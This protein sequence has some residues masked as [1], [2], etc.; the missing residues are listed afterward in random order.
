MRTKS[1]TIYIR[2][3][4]TARTPTPSIR[5]EKFEKPE[6]TKVSSNYSRERGKERNRETD[7]R[8]MIMRKIRPRI[9]S[10]KRSCLLLSRRRAIL[11][12]SN[13]DS[14]R[15]YSRFAGFTAITQITLVEVSSNDTRYIRKERELGQ[16]IK[17]VSHYTRYRTGRKIFYEHI[18]V[19]RYKWSGKT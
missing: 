7:N 6:R 11:F 15:H 3:W 19:I 8:F 12:F 16:E 5:R 10:T 9:I 18:F 14:S 2:H 13:Y 17:D 1:V 4:L